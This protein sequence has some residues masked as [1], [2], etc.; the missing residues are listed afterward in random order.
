MIVEE[1]FEYVFNE[2]LC[3][4]CVNFGNCS[5]ERN[6]LSDC[7]KRDIVYKLLKER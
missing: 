2:S 7:Y 6:W 4:M 5:I 3:P 1:S